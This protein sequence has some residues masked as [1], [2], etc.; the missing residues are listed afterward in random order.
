MTRKQGNLRGLLRLRSVREQDSRIG[1]ATALQEEREAAAKLAD[2]QQLLES[3]PMP[4]AS[5]L[6]AF[7]GRQHTIGLVRDALAD[8]RATLETA[9]ILTAAARER[10]ASDRSRLAAVESLVERRAAAARAERQRRETRELDEVA[11]EMW[12]R[13]T[14]LAVA[15]GGAR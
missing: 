14:L 13:R 2:L 10:W 4:A 15:V 6:A 12:R 8:T 5:D 1:L 11:E 9:R 7:Q 3:L